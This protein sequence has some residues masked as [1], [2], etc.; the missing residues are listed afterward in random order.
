GV[1]T[2]RISGGCNRSG[3]Q[4][5]YVGPGATMGQSVWA[6][7]GVVITDMAALGS[8]PAYYDFDAFEEMQVSTGGSDTTL[9]TPGVSLNMVTKRGTHEGRRTRRYIKAT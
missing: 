2:G 1:L 6:V 9:A 7:D 5:N 3:Q 4:A 8:S